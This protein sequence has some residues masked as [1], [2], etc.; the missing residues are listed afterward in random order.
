MELWSTVIVGITLLYSSYLDLKKREVEDIV[1]VVPAAAGF[2][3]NFYFFHSLGLDW[4]LRYGAV[5]LVSAG[6]AFAFYFAGLYG[7]ADAKALVAI[8]FIQPFSSSSP[9]IHGVTALTVLTNGMILS[10]SLPI[11]FGLFNSYRLLRG[12]KIFE[13]FEAEKPYRRLVALFLGTRVKNAAGKSFWG[14]MET[15]EEGVRKF[16]FNLGIEELEKVER[17]DVWITPGIPLLIFFTAGYFLNFFA[18]DL[19]AH[20]F[21]RLSS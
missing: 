2:A 7:G 4:W 11:F 20:L 12:E 5:I 9:Q 15:F 3:F 8:S 19:M 16:R 14:V 6:L 13:G 18:G 1:W 17:N 10:I 21:M